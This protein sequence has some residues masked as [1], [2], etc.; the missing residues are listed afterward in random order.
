MSFPIAV[1]VPTYNRQF[2]LAQAVRSV[3]RQE[4]VDVEVIVVDDGSSEG[5][6]GSVLDDRRVRVVVTP[7]PGSGEGAAR[8][9]GIATVAAE[10]LAFCDDDDLWHPRK[11]ATQLDAA[12]GAQWMTCGSAAFSLT[13]AGRPIVRTVTAPISSEALLARLQRRGGL[14]GGTSGVVVRTDLVREAGGFRNL[15][16]GADWDLWLRLAERAPLAV[17]ADRLVAN[18][19]HPKSVTADPLRLRK[20][21]DDVAALHTGADTSLPVRP[22]VEVHLRWYA[23]VACRS[24]QRRLA[25]A[26]QNEAATH[27]GK[28]TDRLLALLMFAAPRTVDRARVFRRRWAIP[29]HDRE[30]VERW[31]SEALRP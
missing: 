15:P 20:G 26:F 12:D 9:A 19:V 24:G 30:E 6:L 4:E 16:I 29:R 3:L 21:M 14:P 8:N 23:E 27:S 22:D 5:A 1:V 25:M 17:V 31:V 13:R 18:R 2:E 7:R 28:G 11:L 10:W